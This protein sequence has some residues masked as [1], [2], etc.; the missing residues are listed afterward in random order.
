MH[1]VQGASPAQVSELLDRL[2]PAFYIVGAPRCGTTSLS[3]ALA[4]H[5]QI[6]FSRP[7]ETHYLIDD[8]PGLRTKDIQRL[9]L[10][11]FHPDLVPE[12]RA[13]GDGSVSYL[14]YPQTIERALALDSRA[15]FIVSVRNPVDMLRS[16]HA[17]L[18]YMLDENITDFTRAWAL[19]GDRH[20]GHHIPRRCRDAQLLQYGEVAKLGK[21]VSRLFSLAGREHCHVVVF[22]DFVRDP[23]SVYEQ[24]L[25]FL[26]I[27]D[28]GRSKFRTKSTNAGFRSPWLQR[29]VMNP[30]AWTYPLIKFGNVKMLSHLKGLRKRIKRFNK[31]PE[32]RQIF[33]PALRAT[34]CEYYSD[35]VKTLSGLLDRDLSHWLL[36]PPRGTG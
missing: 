17:R 35:D 2:P 23:R 22:D 28:D 16:Y 8:C 14:Y 4:G 5:P 13:I 6:S 3:K 7:K 18:L 25:A 15:K 21:H 31:V 9:Y 33:S 24:V 27:A 20:A 26:G 10:E 12:T 36:D 19:Q 34:L 30:P 32:A 1:M 29:F 11:R